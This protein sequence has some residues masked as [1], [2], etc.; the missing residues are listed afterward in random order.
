M[1][2]RGFIIILIVILIIILITP[3]SNATTATVIINF[4]YDDIVYEFKQN[5]T[6]K[7]KI[8][9]TI[10]CNMDGLGKEVQYV[11]VHLFLGDRYDWLY[12]C[13]SVHQH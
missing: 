1:G 5:D 6:R 11:E 8:N 10:T 9:F 3:T 7:F 12:N 4:E 2:Q 13:D